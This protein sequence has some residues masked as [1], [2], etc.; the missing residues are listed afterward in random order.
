MIMIVHATSTLPWCSWVFL[1][2]ST[3]DLL[4]FQTGFVQQM[5]SSN[6]QGRP[7][8]LKIGS[9]TR[10]FCASV[11]CCGW[12]LVD[13]WPAPAAACALKPFMVFKFSCLLEA[14]QPIEENGDPTC[15]SASHE[16]PGKFHG[17]AGIARLYFAVGW[18]VGS[19]K[20]NLERARRRHRCL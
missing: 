8:R 6:K 4:T 20:T 1:L 7:P 11:I 13:C 19:K 12:G 15:V 16:D 9:N 14:A 3:G 2:V 17:D 5:A 10:A 18:F